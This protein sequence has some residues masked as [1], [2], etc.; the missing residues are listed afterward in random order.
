MLS[1]APESG[2]EPL[3]EEAAGTE[4]VADEVRRLA[5]R[6]SPERAREAMRLALDKREVDGALVLALVLLAHGEPPPAGAVER[7]FPDA[8]DD[9]AAQILVASHPE[10]LAIL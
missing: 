8:I 10:R 4:P 7:I 1:N 5:E 3:V 2:L 9:R 6:V